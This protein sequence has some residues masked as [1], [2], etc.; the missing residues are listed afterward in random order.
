MDSSSPAPVVLFAP[1]AARRRATWALLAVPVAVALA[2]ALPRWWVI[3]LAVLATAQVPAE[4]LWVRTAHLTIDQRGVR[5]EAPVRGFDVAWGDLTGWRLRR[6]G[7]G[8]AAS[9][10]W[11]LTLHTPTRRAAVRAF[12]WQQDDALRALAPRVEALAGAHG[13]PDGWP[14]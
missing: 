11:M 10:E 5:W 9:T 7:V 1:P 14:R 2:V 3:A 6:I 12:V 8:G 4:A 13:L